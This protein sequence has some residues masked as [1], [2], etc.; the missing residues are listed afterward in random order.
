MAFGF[1]PKHI[2]RKAIEGLSQEQFIV[3]AIEAAKKLSW[4]SVTSVERALLLTQSSRLVL[5][6]KRSRLL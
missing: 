2:E 6:A 4:I 5:L 3:I 1:S